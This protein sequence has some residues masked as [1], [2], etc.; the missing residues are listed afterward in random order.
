LRIKGWSG[1]RIK[2]E[3]RDGWEEKKREGRMMKKG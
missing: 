3:N 1:E 2:G